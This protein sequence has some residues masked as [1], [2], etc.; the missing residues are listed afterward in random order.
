MIATGRSFAP[1][2][3]VSPGE[4]HTQGSSVE[5]KTVVTVHLSGRENPMMD[6]DFGRILGFVSHHVG[7]SVVTMSV[8]RGSWSSRPPP[9]F[10]LRVVQEAIRGEDPLHLIR[11]FRGRDNDSANA[12]AMYG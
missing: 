4:A 9:S 1:P 11:L 7:V 6:C 2:S 3:H 5:S 10:R 8:D 12:D